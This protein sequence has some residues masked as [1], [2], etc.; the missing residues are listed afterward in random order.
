MSLDHHRRV[1]LGGSPVD[2]AH[3]D[4]AVRLIAD[5]AS[6]AVDAPLGVLSVNVDHLN[7]FGHGGRWQHVLEHRG[8]QAPGTGSEEPP[9]LVLV[10]GAR[11]ATAWTDAPAASDREKPVE[12][13]SLIDGSPLAAQARRL[14]GTAWP[15]LAGSDLIGPLLD[16]AARDGVRVGVLGGSAEAQDRLR[17]RLAHERPD[18]VLAGLWSPSR[19]QLADA[20]AN[21][22]LV[23]AIRRAAVDLLIVGLGKPRQELWIDEHG[24]RTGARVLLAFGAAVD[25]LGGSVRRA[26]KWVADHG[27]EWLWR[28][29]LEPRRLARRYLVEGPLAYGRL[30]L[31]STVEPDRGTNLHGLVRRPA[32]APEGS[33][34][35]GRFVGDGEHADVAALV[36]SYRSAS[37]LERLLESLREEARC[38]LRLRVVVVDNASD[39]G[40]L[41]AAAAHPDVVALDAGGNVGYAAALNIARRHAGD[42]DALLVL[43]PDLV[44]LP[45]AVSRLLARMEESEAGIVVPLL[46]DGSGAPSRSLR[47][48]PTRLRALGDAVLGDRMVD[49]PAFSSE[50]D[51]DPE[52][53]RHAHAIEWATG[54]ALLI[55]SLVA[56][57]LGDW[58]ERFFLYSEETDYFRR[59][60][61]LGAEAWFE[62]SA[63]VVHEGA[64]S[65]ASSAL[66]ALLAVNR[67]RY[68]EK[69][70]GA[71]YSWTFR[72]VVLAAETARAA[73]PGER[74]RGHRR[75]ALA[76]AVGP[77]RAGIPR[78]EVVTRSAPS[79][80]SG[81]IVIPAHDE[82]AVIGRTLAPLAAAAAAGA[83]EVVVVCNACGD[84]TAD[85]ARGFAGVTVVE[86]EEASKTAAL[87]AGDAA[88][89]TWPRLYLDADVDVT[90][91]AVWNVFDA[92]TR[93]GLLAARPTAVYDVTDADRL[94]RAYYRARSRVPS[95]GTALWGAGS[96]A[97]S[98]PGH[99]RIG[100]FPALIADDEFV[101]GRFAPAERAVV[102]TAPAVVRVPRSA[103]SLVGVL[104]RSHRGTA[105]LAELAGCG[106]RRSARTA[107]DVLR[108]AQGPLELAD[109]AVYLAF[110]LASRVP[111]RAA[112]GWTRDETT[113]VAPASDRRRG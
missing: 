55:D 26:P 45:G 29:A 85:I 42:A 101:D 7:H 112:A 10:P 56:A 13:I 28:L 111:D 66:A 107:V 43:N 1:V 102:A 35:Q 61:E 6:S 92:L 31:H 32:V 109:A 96:Y 103:S 58:D 63:Q 37:T 25:F 89:R 3:H 64:G 83:L 73:L 24:P 77:G 53:Y 8:A 113:R 39:D 12:W 82:E 76:L 46:R 91:G 62:P 71:L 105:Q 30:R 22:D 11:G 41:Q 9:T 110:A 67:V 108:A 20:E 81:S 44:V 97:V 78:G 51:S 84:R 49:R 98:A 95:L 38:G 34:G 47:R 18:L 93:G 15:R 79:L 2:L 52:S 90:A 50:T 17:E 19:Q 40:S 65:G 48:E 5:R 16:R 86:I 57:R 94:V 59:A 88:A 70:H 68:V 80:P 104:R 106:E 36:V 72:L 74:G 99:D 100:S 27:V 33:A 69:F 54:A 60:R 4:E 21:A 87:N 23:E 14:T 75:A